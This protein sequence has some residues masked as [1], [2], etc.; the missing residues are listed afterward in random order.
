LSVANG[1]GNTISAI[2][3]Q[4][5]NIPSTYSDAATMDAT[6]YLLDYPTQFPITATTALIRIGCLSKQRFVR[7]GITTTTSGSLTVLGIGEL[8]NAIDQ[9]IVVTSS[10]LATSDINCPSVEADSN[11]TFPKR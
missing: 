9:P 10:T 7:I 8:N 6:K 11:I 1:A 2:V 5:A 3:F 4:E